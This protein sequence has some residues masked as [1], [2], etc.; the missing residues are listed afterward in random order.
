[1]DDENME[2]AINMDE[3]SNAITSLW[4][5]AENCRLPRDAKASNIVPNI[6]SNLAD[7]GLTGPLSMYIYGNILPHVDRNGNHKGFT[8]KQHVDLFASSCVSFQHVPGDN[9]KADSTD[10]RMILGMMNWG[11]HHSPPANYVIISGDGDF[12]YTV[13]NLRMMKYKVLLIQPKVAVDT[14]VASTQTV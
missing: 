5:D 7:I 3:F 10:K 6:A 11:Y 1:M 2:E 8:S 14:L 9:N 13:H 4:W 12:S